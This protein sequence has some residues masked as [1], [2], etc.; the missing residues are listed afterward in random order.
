ME[1]ASHNSSVWPLSNTTVDWTFS[2]DE[3]DLLRQQLRGPLACVWLTIL[4]TGLFGN[5]AFLYVRTTVAYMNTVTNCYLMNLGLADIM[6]L[7]ITVPLETCDLFY[8]V[9]PRFQTLYCVLSSGVT[10]LSN[11]T[12]ML[13]LALIT[14]ERYFAICKPYQAKRLS[15]KSRAR[16]VI[17]VTWAVAFTFA[18]VFTISCFSKGGLGINAIT[19][20]LQTLPFIV[21][22]STITVLNILIVRTLSRR[23]HGTISAQDSD[24]R[25]ERLQ[26]IKLLIVTELLF[27]LCVFPYYLIDV[28]LAT[29]VLANTCIQTKT[30][31]SITQLYIVMVSMK[32]LMYINSAI[33]PLIYN[34]MS[35]RYRLAF[36]SAFQCRQQSIYESGMQASTQL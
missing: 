34:V 14:L 31:M 2:S 23:N 24:A 18:V 36:L 8:E 22:M 9:A 26:V 27:F 7:A 30:C 6:F 15:S 10:H 4:V 5:L 35:S 29:Q 17:A 11:Y 16:R 19:L 32:S 13:T 1:L 12:S 33:D 3:Y 20:I 25:A 21:S 28:I